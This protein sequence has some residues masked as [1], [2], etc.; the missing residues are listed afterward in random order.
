MDKVTKL[1][2]TAVV[3]AAAVFAFS[4]QENEEKTSSTK[5]DKNLIS[6]LIDKASSKSQTEDSEVK[7]DD[8]EPSADNKK[9]NKR[10]LELPGRLIGTPERIVSHYAYTLSFNR[11]HNQP[12]WV[13]W[14]LTDKETDGHIQRSNDF[15]PDPMIPTPHRVTTDDYKGSGYDRGHMAPAADMKWSGKAMTECFY[16]SNM[17]PQHGS[18]N[19]GPWATLEKAC[20]RWAQQEGSVYIVCGPVF[21]GTKHK[22]IGKNV[23]VTV[24]E[25]FF[26]VILSMKKGKE[27]AIGFYYNNKSGKQPMDKTATTVDAIEE[28]T[29]MDFFVNI[30]DKLEKQI[31]ASYSLK[32]WK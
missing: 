12:N 21:K 5:Q 8:A 11:E 20:R 16:M 18:L 4:N 19:S 24:P 9:G 17:C 13:A 28:M 6:Q 27:K 23:K 22:Y 7:A 25:G 26:K 31:E 29:S 32:E 14:E 1:L 10:L 30:P 3:I 2:G 15:I